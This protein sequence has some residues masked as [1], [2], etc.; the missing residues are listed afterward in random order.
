MLYSYF[1]PLPGSVLNTCNNFCIQGS[2]KTS[3]VSGFD[4]IS[5]IFFSS[6]A[7]ACFGFVELLTDMSA[8]FWVCL[9]STVPP[10]EAIGGLVGVYT[11]ASDGSI[12]C[13]LEGLG[14][15]AGV[16]FFSPKF[17]KWFPVSQKKKCVIL[18]KYM[19]FGK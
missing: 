14:C 7:V 16:G 15:A 5:C 8:P 4:K 2:I 19:F 18:R 6:S 12:S 17:E 10:E 3:I 9:V 1:C 13:I 11:V